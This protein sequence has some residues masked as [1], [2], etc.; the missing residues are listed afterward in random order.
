MVDINNYFLALSQ[1]FG[2]NLVFTVILSLE[3]IKSILMQFIFIFIYIV[4]FNVLKRGKIIYLNIKEWYIT[5]EDIEKTRHEYPAWIYMYW[6]KKKNQEYE[7]EDYEEHKLRIIPL[8]GSPRFQRTV[9]LC[10][11]SGF[12]RRIS[13]RGFQQ[14]W[15]VQSRMG[16]L[17][18]F[19]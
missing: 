16:F 4:D 15:W 9:V 6:E 12:W 14:L 10:Q 13:I 5:W 11:C 17:S 3:N 18:G 8:E 2:Y 7:K 1:L 19:S